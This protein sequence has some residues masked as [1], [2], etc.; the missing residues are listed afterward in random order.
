MS[1]SGNS[2]EIHQACDC[3]TDQLGRMVDLAIR[4]GKK[5]SVAMGEL[6]EP[7]EGL[8]DPG[9]VMMWVQ[10]PIDL[11]PMASTP[12]DATTLTAL[13]ESIDRDVEHWHHIMSEFA[14]MKDTVSSRVAAGTVDLF[15]RW[16]AHFQAHTE[17][18]LLQMWMARPLTGETI[19]TFD[20]LQEFSVFSD[21]DLGETT[22]FSRWVVQACAVAALDLLTNAP[23]VVQSRSIF[24]FRAGM[25][26]TQSERRAVA[27]DLARALCLG[28]PTVWSSTCSTSVYAPST[29]VFRETVLSLQQDDIVQ[30]AKELMGVR[31]ASDAPMAGRRADPTDKPA[32][33]EVLEQPTSPTISSVW[34]AVKNSEPKLKGITMVLRW[35][36]APTNAVLRMQSGFS[37]MRL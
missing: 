19:P 32:L 34:A 8:R 23:L 2:S 17:P 31:D 26:T 30:R 24:S 22:A 6:R 7:P 21:S 14:C 20:V 33:P 25:P 13:L 10:P 36:C 28:Q 29:H 11:G 16:L 5:A 4:G 37:Q 12:H 35:C 18:R 3:S 1:E 9:S 15:L 27:Q